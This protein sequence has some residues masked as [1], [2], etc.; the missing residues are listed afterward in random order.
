M[1]ESALRPKSQRASDTA[2]LVE[3][4]E[5][6]RRS[7]KDLSSHRQVLEQDGVE[8]GRDVHAKYRQE[9]IQMKK[10]MTALGEVDANEAAPSAVQTWFERFGEKI[11]DFLAEPSAGQIVIC[12]L[13]VLLGF[14]AAFAF[15]VG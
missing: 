6:R 11:G 15:L 3:R 10:T 2:R 14:A 13:L 9:L 1:I 8:T 5:P 4:S 7:T 12:I